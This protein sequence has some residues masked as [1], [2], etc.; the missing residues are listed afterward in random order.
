MLAL[1]HEGSNR[2]DLAVADLAEGEL[3]LAAGATALPPLPGLARLEAAL[4]PYRNGLAALAGKVDRPPKQ[5]QTPSQQTSP[6]SVLNEMAAA[7]ARTG[8]GSSLSSGGWDK[9]EAALLASAS[10]TSVASLSARLQS[11]T[12]A[13]LSS[14]EQEELTWA[15]TGLCTVFHDYVAQALLGKV[16][17][18]TIADVGGAHPPA[19]LPDLCFEVIYDCG[20]ETKRDCWLP[21][22]TDSIYVRVPA[23]VVYTI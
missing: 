6:P 4:M 11:P 3:R 19:T 18:F 23:Q 14:T 7:A 16:R 1:L 17:H 2:P 8:S 12:K 22:E 10:A 20:F 9:A 13:A 21:I 5:Q 15:V